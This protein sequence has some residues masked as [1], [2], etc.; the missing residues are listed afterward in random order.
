MSELSFEATPVKRRWA[1]AL[2][3]ALRATRDTANKARVPEFIPLLGGAGAG[4]I[5]LG[6]APEGAER[7]AYGERMTSGRGQTLHIRPEMIDLA[8]AM[9]INAGLK[10][11]VGLVGRMTDKASDATINALRRAPQ[12]VAAAERRMLREA[13]PEGEE[14]ANYMSRPTVIAPERITFPG[15][16]KR[17]DALVAGARVAPEDPLMKQLF[18]VT[19]D[20]L[21]QIAQEGQRAGNMTDTPFKTAAKPRGAAVAEQIMNPRN[22]QRIIDIIAEARKRPDLFKGMASW[23]T[24]DPLYQR[25]VELYGREAAPS[26]Y[27]RFNALTGMASPNSEVLTELNRGTGAFWL[28]NQGRFDDFA[29]YAGLAE[30]KRGADFPQDMRAIQGH[31]VH[32]TAQAGPMAKYLRAGQIEMDSPKVP[33]YIHASGVPDV[34]FQTAWPVGDAHWSRLV[35]LPDVRGLKRDRETGN[36]VPNA[37]SASTS[38]MVSLGPWW[39][40]RVADR[41]DLESVPAQA[42]VWGAG[43]NATGVSSPIGAPKLELLSQQIGKAANRMGISPEEARDR[44]IMGSGHAGFIDPKLA[45]IMAGGAGASAA[46]IAALRKKQEDEE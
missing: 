38:E 27:Q 6:Q 45:A 44:I 35:G 40:K 7:L 5:L 21:Y 33:S 36:M 43:S 19:R 20:D 2:A 25:F 14:I 32:S 46:A 18:G 22:E 8:M 24:M 37:A 11:G 39:R 17:P 31:M 41:S 28:A 42:V 34:G 16:Y 15:I 3:E 29:R 12:T 30:S 13:I 4:D 26:M 10:G 9:P 1:M 23:Y